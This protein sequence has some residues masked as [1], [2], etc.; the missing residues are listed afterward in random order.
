MNQWDLWVVE[1]IQCGKVKS[2]KLK[3][4][5]DT[6]NPFISQSLCF[7]ILATVKELTT[8]TRYSK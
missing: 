3:K 2:T 7:L 1:Y 8:V 6:S 4:S 5:T